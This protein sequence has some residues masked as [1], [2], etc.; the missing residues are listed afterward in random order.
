MSFL[1]SLSARLGGALVLYGAWGLFAFS[2]LDS[3]ILAFPLVNDL[4]LIHLSSQFPVRTPIYVLACTAGSLAGAF[5]LYGLGYGGGKFL[6]RKFSPEKTTR[7]RRWIE[8]NDFVAV[9]VVS[10]LPPPAPFKL[11]L[12]T[13]GA[14]RVSAARFGAALLVGRGLRFAAEGALGARY[15]AQAETYLKQ[16]VGWISLAAAALVVGAV[17]GRRRLSKAGRR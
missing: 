7:A 2:F 11:F 5:V 8:R 3:S 1:K 13:A 6:A 4:L 10:L 14:L 12:V 9:L 17:I 16:N 15:G